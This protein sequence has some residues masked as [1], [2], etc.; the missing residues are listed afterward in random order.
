MAKYPNGVN[1]RFKRPAKPES[2]KAVFE[3]MRAMR[4]YSNADIYKRLPFHLAKSTIANIRTRRTRYPSHITC[5]AVARAV[6]MR[7]ELV[8]AGE[9]RADRRAQGTERWPASL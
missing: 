6:G 1:F 3:L 7:W 4:G 9:Q 2:D 8:E 5:V